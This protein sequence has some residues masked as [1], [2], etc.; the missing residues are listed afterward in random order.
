MTSYMVGYQCTV[1]HVDATSDVD[2]MQ[3]FKNVTVVM[4]FMY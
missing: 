2:V 4:I 3:I 1:L